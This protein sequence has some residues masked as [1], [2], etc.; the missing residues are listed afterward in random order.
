MLSVRQSF[1]AQATIPVM[2]SLSMIEGVYRPWPVERVAQGVRVT[3]SKCW[4]F[5]RP[6]LAA[7]ARRRP[8]LTSAPHHNYARQP[9]AVL[10]ESFGA[11]T[12]QVLCGKLLL[13]TR[14]PRQAFF[15]ASCSASGS[16]TGQKAIM[17]CLKK[18]DRQVLKNCWLSLSHRV[19]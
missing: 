1:P 2:G 14:I 4:M 18:K 9:F 8:G 6:I 5:Y 17:S 16:Q 15:T 13:Q 3:C 12:T 10:C 7:C 11:N 19:H